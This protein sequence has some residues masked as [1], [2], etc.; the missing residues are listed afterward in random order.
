MIRALLTRDAKEARPY[1][2]WAEEVVTG[3]R[4]I[5]AGH[6]RAGYGRASW[7]PLIEQLSGD[8]VDG[9]TLTPG[10]GP[11]EVELVVRAVHRRR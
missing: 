2:L 3:L 4:H 7:L 11:L 10:G 8:D 5:E 6:W 1:A 9:I